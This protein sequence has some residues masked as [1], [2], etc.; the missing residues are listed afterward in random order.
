M[1]ISEPNPYL[2]LVPILGLIIFG[3]ATWVDSVYFE[4]ELF[5]FV[6]AFAKYLIILIIFGAIFLGNIL[7][8]K[9]YRKFVQDIKTYGQKKKID[10]YEVLP[11]FEDFLPLLKA[12]VQINGK[13][14]EISKDVPPI[15]TEVIHK[16]VPVTLYYDPT[17]ITNF[18]YYLDLTEDLTDETLKK[19]QQM[20][21]R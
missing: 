12:T 21:N 15:L 2:F 20:A 19:S 8:K 3:V 11:A 9:A 1:H 4:N 14:Q 13:E 5:S 18:V 7:Y 17:N 16:K 6:P 10:D